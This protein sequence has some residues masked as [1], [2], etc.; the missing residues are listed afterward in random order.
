MVLGTAGSGKTTLAIHRA[1]YLT[2]P[3]IDHGGRL[4]ADNDSPARAGSILEEW[5]L[6]TFFESNRFGNHYEFVYCAGQ[7]EVRTAQGLSRLQPLPEVRPEDLVL[8]PG[9]DSKTLDKE[10]PN[11]T[12]WLRAARASGALIGPICTSA[13]SSRRQDSSMARSVQRIGSLLTGLLGSIQNSK[14]PRI[15][16]LFMT[17]EL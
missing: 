2:N 4:V 17:A 13:L 6:Q 8:V 14:L 7:T 15:S 3:S 9:I 16:S 1:V 11:H 5:P 10:R 12:S